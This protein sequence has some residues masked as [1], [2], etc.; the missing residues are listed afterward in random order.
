MTNGTIV[1]PMARSRRL[2]IEKPRAL[3]RKGFSD[4]RG[5]R[6]DQEVQETSIDRRLPTDDAVCSS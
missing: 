4:D 1:S 3:P 2:P 5:I 6:F